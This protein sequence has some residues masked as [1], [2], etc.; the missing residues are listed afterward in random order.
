MIQGEPRSKESLVK[1]RRK[2]RPFSFPPLCVIMVQKRGGVFMRLT[3]VNLPTMDLPRMRDFYCMALKV[4]YDESHGGP[5]RCEILTQGATLVLCK[6]HTPPV[7]D[8]ESC[9]LEFQVENV[10]EE[11]QR[12]L[13]QGVTI[14]NP[15]VTLPWG[16]RF[17]AFRDPDGNNIDLVQAL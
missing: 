17:I 4:G 13:G 9:G 8:P 7:I 16:F 10:D 1:G 6:T 3:C 15:P 2:K 14:P 11:Y 12:L 5:D